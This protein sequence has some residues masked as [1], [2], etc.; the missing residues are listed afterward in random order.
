MRAQGETGKFLQK[1]IWWVE[2]QT[3]CMTKNIVIDGGKEHAKS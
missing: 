1:Q 2:R 3:D